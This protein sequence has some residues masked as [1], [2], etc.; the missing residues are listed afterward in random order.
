MKHKNGRNNMFCLLFVFY[1]ILFDN[2]APVGNFDR[3]SKKHFVCVCKSVE[4]Q[5]SQK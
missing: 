5:C 2:L 3:T 4:A 1:C